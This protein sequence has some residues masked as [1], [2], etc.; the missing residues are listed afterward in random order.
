MKSLSPPNASAIERLDG[1]RR[2]GLEV[3]GS[4]RRSLLRM[5]DEQAIDMDVYYVLQEEIDWRELTLLPDDER[6]IDE[7]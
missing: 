4:Q 2:L 7:I 5:R 6:R 3:I 1:Y